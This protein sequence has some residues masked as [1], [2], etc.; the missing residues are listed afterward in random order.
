MRRTR[1]HVY[2][3]VIGDALEVLAI[4]K[5]SVRSATDLRDVDATS[6]SSSAST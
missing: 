6:Q 1:Y 5:V 3:R 4:W 2:Y